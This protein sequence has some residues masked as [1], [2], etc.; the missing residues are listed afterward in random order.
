MND[1]LTGA[2]PPG[3]ASRR[4]RPAAVRSWPLLLL[5][6]P[7]SA[8]VWSGWVGYRANTGFGVVR[9]L[10]GI[11]DSVRTDTAITLPLG[12]EAYAAFSCE[13]GSA[14]ARW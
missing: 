7:A 6:A 11:A 5:V 10:P 4:S 3:I 2:A 14:R 12:V 13:R 9:P 1:V 8:A